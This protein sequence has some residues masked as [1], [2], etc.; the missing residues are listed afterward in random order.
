MRGPRGFQ[1]EGQG[2]GRVC[3]GARSKGVLGWERGPGSGGGVGD[4]GGVE[5]WVQL[6]RE[7][8]PEAELV[9]GNGKVARL[10]ATA[11]QIAVIHGDQV[12]VT[13]DEAV[14]GGV[15]LQCL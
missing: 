11:V 4:G 6:R 8:A 12:H 1:T 3:V 13:E 9:H 7:P 15:L 10:V 5:V 2:L 14:V